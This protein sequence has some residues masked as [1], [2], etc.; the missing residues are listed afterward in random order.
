MA[1]VCQEEILEHLHSRM[2]NRH[3]LP[4]QGKKLKFLT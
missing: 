1:S 4:G 2:V 3:F